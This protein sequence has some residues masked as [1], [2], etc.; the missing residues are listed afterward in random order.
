M[1]L[2]PSWVTGPRK[3]SSTDATSIDQENFN[4]LMNSANTLVQRVPP[5]YYDVSTEQGRQRMIGM[6]LRLADGSRFPFDHISSHLCDDKVLVFIVPHNKSDAVILEDD[7][8]LFPSDT[9]ITQLRLL[10]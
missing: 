7:P 4:A 10:T 8:N 5:T 9:L 3:V 6:R 2:F 1:T